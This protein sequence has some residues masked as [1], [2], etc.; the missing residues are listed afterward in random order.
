[1]L[2][3]MEEPF[4][5]LGN[6]MDFINA[7]AAPAQCFC[8]H[9]D[10]LIVDTGQILFDAGI[11]PAVHF[12]H[13]Q[14][15][16]ADFQGADSLQERPL[17]GT[18]YAHDLAGGLHLGTQGLI[19]VHEFIEGPAGE[20]HHTVVQGRLEASLCLLCDCIGDFIQAVADGNLG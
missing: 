6:L 15:V 10:A 7:R 14:A 2:H 13:V 17:E 5:H 1:M 12:F 3:L 8:N 9:E 18:V 19:R 16:H 20:L 11:V 4:V